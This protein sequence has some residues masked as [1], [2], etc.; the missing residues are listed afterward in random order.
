MEASNYDL[1]SFWLYAEKQP[2]TIAALCY[3]YKQKRHT[4][5]VMTTI[6]YGLVNK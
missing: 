1:Q 2:I 6:S 3:E 5:S 4:C